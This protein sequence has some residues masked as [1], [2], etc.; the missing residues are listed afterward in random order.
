MSKGLNTS[1]RGAVAGFSYNSPF[2][3]DTGSSGFTNVSSSMPAYA[4]AYEI[5][6]QM[7]EVSH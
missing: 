2:N 3:A 4:G 6:G 7:W 5:S 1:L